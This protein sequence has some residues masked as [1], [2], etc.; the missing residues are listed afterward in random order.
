MR[1]ANIR[2]AVKRGIFHAVA[3]L[4][5]ILVLYFL[6]YITFV[7]TLAIVT[8]IFLSF[9]LVRLRIDAINKWFISWFGFL[10]RDEEKNKLT[11]SSYSLLGFLITVLA[12]DRDIAILAILFVSLGDPVATV[13][14]IWKGRIVL[15]GRSI[16]GN[17]ACFVVCL[18]M[19]LLATKIL[20]NL[21]FPMIVIGAIFAT[22][23]QAVPQK[24]N[25][26]LTIP[27]GS[28]LAMLVTKIIT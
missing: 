5:V 11:G 23:F 16:E 21:T 6:P 14:G 9:E 20:D 18:T 15:W 25:D 27:I 1:L 13:V 24:V 28:A 10:M 4:F 26:N 8:G 3:G 2:H 7:V 12:F 22:V 19:G 17:I